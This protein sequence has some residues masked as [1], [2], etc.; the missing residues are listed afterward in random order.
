[1]RQ[2]VLQIMP[3]YRLPEWIGP[4]RGLENAAR[5][6]VQFVFHGFLQA[7]APDR[8]AS[9]ARTNAPQVLE[10]EAFAT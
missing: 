1:M 3:N 7:Q 6:T 5:D 4:P 10:P 8:A 9:A 2:E